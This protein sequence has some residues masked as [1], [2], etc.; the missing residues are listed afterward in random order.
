MRAIGKRVHHEP[1]IDAGAEHGDLRL[2]RPLVDLP[3][4]TDV[5][6]TGIRQLLGRRDDRR[7]RLQ[8]RLDL[9][10][11]FLDRRTGAQDH[12]VRLAR[13]ERL[14]GVGRHL[15]AEPARQTRHVAEIASDHRR[16]DVDAGDDLESRPPGH[17]LEDGCADRTQAKV[18]HAD[19]RHRRIIPVAFLYAAEAMM[20]LMPS[21]SSDSTCSSSSAM[22]RTAP[23]FFA[24][25]WRAVS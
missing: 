7:F 10:Q 21:A 17:L 13:L 20:A 5:R 2:L 23:R 12:D 9:R 15:D 18:H 14:R 25:I 24:T 4:L 16:I 1:G 8:D 19:V 11:D 6:V 3:R 22:A